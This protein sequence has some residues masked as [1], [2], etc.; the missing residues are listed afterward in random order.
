MLFY[1]ILAEH[2]DKY[3]L[4]IHIEGSDM[5]PSASVHS[6]KVNKNNNDLNFSIVHSYTNC[7]VF[8]ISK[9]EMT[10]TLYNIN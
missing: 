1:W 9:L 2:K 4:R 10:S 6:N 7:F 3:K 8:C 5:T